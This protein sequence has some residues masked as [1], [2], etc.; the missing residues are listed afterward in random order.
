MKRI[1]IIAAALWLCLAT[2][3]VAVKHPG[4]TTGRIVQPPGGTAGQQIIVLFQW[5]VGGTGY[6]L[7]S[8][9]EYTVQNGCK[10]VWRQYWRGP[11]PVGPPI[12][13]G[14]FC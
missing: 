12:L 10:Q 2:T 6:N 11:V 14:E 9:I 7:T 4:P 3:S 13:V 1:A 8:T 5:I